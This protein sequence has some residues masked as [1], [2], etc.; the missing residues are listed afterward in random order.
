MRAEGTAQSDWVLIDAGDVIVHLF[1]DEVR[2][3][4]DLEKLG[5]RRCPRTPTRSVCAPRRRRAGP[6]RRPHATIAAVGRDRSGPARL[7][8][9]DYCRRCP[10]PVNGGS[11][12]RG[13]ASMERR[14]AE[15]AERLSSAV[16]ATR[17]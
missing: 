10:W 3:F 5:A 14:L 8:F 7:L 1:K 16:R 15:E 2:H 17:F 4:Y 13:A 6:A 11:A 12:A 9:D